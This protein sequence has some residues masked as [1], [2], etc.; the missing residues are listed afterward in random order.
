MPVPN[1]HFN[2]VQQTLTIQ[3]YLEQKSR[4]GK[5][6]AKTDRTEPRVFGMLAP[7]YVNS[8]DWGISDILIWPDENLKQFN[9]I[10]I[11]LVTEI[12]FNPVP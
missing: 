8:N 7:I 5:W 10:D 2:L 12:F 4:V 9:S 1:K 3:L 6:Q 11:L